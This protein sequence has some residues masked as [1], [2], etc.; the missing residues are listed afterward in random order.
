MSLLPLLN[1]PQV[2]SKINPSNIGTLLGL[3]NG[4]GNDKNDKH[5]ST[6]VQNLTE[7]KETQEEP[8]MPQPVDSIEHQLEIVE[9]DRHESE[10]KTTT[11]LNWKSNF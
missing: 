11:H 8:N 3:L 4:L 1:S 7:Q 2:K 5:K 10:K 9:P 6:K